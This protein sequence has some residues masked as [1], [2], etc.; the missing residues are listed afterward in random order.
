MGSLNGFWQHPIGTGLFRFVSQQI[1][2]DVVLER[3]PLCWSVVPKIERVRFRV[4]PDAIT[5][6][7]ELEKG[8]QPMLRSTL[9]R[10]MLWRHWRHG[11]ICASNKCQAHR[12]SILASI[13]ASPCCAMYAYARQ[14]PLPLIASLLFQPCSAVMRRLQKACFPP[15]IG[16][17]RTKWRIMTT[18]LRAPRNCS[19]R[20]VSSTARMGFDFT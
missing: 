20:P 11:R 1:D 19:M 15:A 10:W 8:T 5:E 14:S 16:P 2:Q 7:L 12:F 13:C 3:N 9:R 6:S 4:V 17:I 18:P